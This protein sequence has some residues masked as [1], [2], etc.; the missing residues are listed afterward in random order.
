ML[1]MRLASAGL[2]AAVLSCIASPA[3]AQ[4]LA[5]SA[6]ILWNAPDDK[7]APAPGTVAPPVVVAS[8]CASCA[9]ATAPAPLAFG[10]PWDTRLKLTGDWGGSRD[11]LAAKGITFDTSLTQ[12]YWANASGGRDQN[13]FYGDR[14]DYFI[15]IDGEKAGLTKG[16]FIQ[17]HAESIFGLSANKAAGTVIPI[18]TG[19]VFPN[20]TDADV[21]LTGIKYTQFLS[22]NFAV[23]GGKLNMLDTWTQP[24]AAGRGVDS[25]MNMSIALPLVF[26]RTVPYSSWGGGFVVLQDLEPI[27]SFMAMDTANTPTSTGFEN[28]FTNGVTMMAQAT[29]PVKFN[30]LPGHYSVGG[31]YSTGQYASI[32]RNSY[33]DPN[34]NSFNLNGQPR[35]GS[36]ALF[37][38]FDQAV[39]VD[40][41]NPKRSFGLFGSI[42]ITDDN[43]S[44]IGWAGNIGVGGS[45][46]FANR[47]A[48]DSFGVGY[49]YTNLSPDIKD[50]APRVL[51]LR[52]EHGIE[53]FYNY[54]LTPYCHISPDFQ[55]VLPGHD[56]FDTTL[57]VGLRMKFDF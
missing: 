42:G 33:F 18:S 30:N 17:L 48:L 53:L 27:F 45:S 8:P 20:S 41:C 11:T 36:W 40:G 51:P 6:V 19:Q 24:F 52:D 34:D 3:S 5:P 10:G 46:P 31:V 50:F 21:A 15:N 38:A 28:F 9:A 55:V 29:L 13:D 39:W 26:A 25:F 14:L 7:A 32:D 54:G 56:R 16:S 49:F 2:A 43:P 44:P 22:E 47:S 4:I 1:K 37:A 35:Q 23:F 12:Y 57:L